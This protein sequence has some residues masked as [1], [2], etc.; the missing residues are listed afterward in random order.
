MHTQ[1]QRQQNKSREVK[2]I[3]KQKTFKENLLFILIKRYQ[4]SGWM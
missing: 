4:K 1:L 3:S 2:W